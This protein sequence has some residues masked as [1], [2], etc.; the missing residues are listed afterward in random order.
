MDVLQEV[1]ALAAQLYGNS[2]TNEAR[3]EAERQLSV[4]SQ[5]PEMLD[6]ARMI[7]DR[8]T[9]PFAQHVAA[10]AMTKLLTLNWG[11]FTSHQRI[12]V[13]NYVC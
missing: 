7:L 1:E 6:Q 12:D 9:Q 5:N 13:R 3:A 10:T 11:R 2:T 4:F 8:S